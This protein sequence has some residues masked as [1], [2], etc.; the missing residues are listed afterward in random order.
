MF[1]ALFSLF[2]PAE[3]LFHLSDVIQMI[4]SLIDKFEGGN[5]NGTGTKNDGI[6]AI[7]Q[8][9]EAHKEKPNG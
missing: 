7:I 6:D 3:A 8:I 4:D 9:L 2:K 5:L 1:N